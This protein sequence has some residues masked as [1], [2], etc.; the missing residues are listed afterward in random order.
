[1]NEFW[2]E[3]KAVL[4]KIQKLSP[5]AQGRMEH[6]Y[7]LRHSPEYR[8][9]LRMIDL[10]ALSQPALYNLSETSQ[11]GQ[12]RALEPIEDVRYQT[13]DKLT[14][15]LKDLENKFYKHIKPKPVE[16]AKPI[17]AVKPIVRKQGINLA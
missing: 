6:E 4:E 14:A 9:E 1:M 7:L 5:E 8:Q 12:E 3:H 17:E 13:I 16:K 15:E 10:E 2:E 11:D